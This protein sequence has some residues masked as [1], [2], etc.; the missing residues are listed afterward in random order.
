MKKFDAKYRKEMEEGVKNCAKVQTAS[1]HA[2]VETF[3]L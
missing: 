2:H 1:K 3:L